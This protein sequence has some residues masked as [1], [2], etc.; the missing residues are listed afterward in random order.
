MSGF[1]VCNK[2]K[3]VPEL[4]DVPVVITSSESSQET[5]DHH[6]KL[7]TRAEDYVHKPITP[8]ELIR[9]CAAHVRID[10]DPGGDSEEVDFDDLEAVALPD[11]PPPTTDAELDNI[12]DVAFDNI[13]LPSDSPGQAAPV[14]V[15][16]P[17]G[18]TGAVAKP[19]PVRGPALVDDDLDDLTMVAS[20]RSIA[21]LQLAMRPTPRPQPAATGHSAAPQG[22]AP[23]AAPPATSAITPANT[24]TATAAPLCS[25]SQPHSSAPSGYSALANRRNAA[26]TR[27]CRPSG[28]MASRRLSCTTL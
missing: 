9:R 23:S 13:M 25:S 2:L 5:F 26:F 16:V 18:S 8:D 7:R 17:T 14:P 12:A 21:D 4:K 22:T 27:P 10:D 6:S 24:P 28:I 1:A 3:K 11:D 20:S 19:A 15:K